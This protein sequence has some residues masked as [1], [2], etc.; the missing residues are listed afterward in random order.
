[1][2][3]G[4]AVHCGS[5]GPGVAGVR[6]VFWAAVSV[7]LA[8]MPAGAPAA[9]AFHGGPGAGPPCTGGR[10]SYS[11]FAWNSNCELAPWS[12]PAKGKSLS[13]LN[14]TCA[15]NL[16]NVVP[17]VHT[18]SLNPAGAACTVDSHRG[19]AARLS[20]PYKTAAPG[21]QTDLG[22]GWPNGTASQPVGRR[23]VEIFYSLTG[24][25]VPKHTKQHQPCIG[26]N[27]YDRSGHI[28][29]VGIS[30]WGQIHDPY[31]GM[32]KFT[33]YATS[34]NLMIDGKVFE[35]GF[36]GPKWA[37]HPQFHVAAQALTSFP[38]ISLNGVDG[39][40]V[41][42][43]SCAEGNA[44][45]NVC[46]CCTVV[47]ADPA[48]RCANIELKTDDHLK[49]AMPALHACSECVAPF[50]CGA[51]GD[52][53]GWSCIG[54]GSSKATAQCS[55]QDEGR[56]SCLSIRSAS[57]SFSI[58][59]WT[60]PVNIS[61]TLAAAG[62]IHSTSETLL[63]RISI[64]Y[65]VSPR[66]LESCTTGPSPRV[67][68]LL[69]SELNASRSWDH[70]P[71]YDL[72]TGK[73]ILCYGQSTRRAQVQT[74]RFGDV[75]LTGTSAPSNLYFTFWMQD[76]L[77]GT[78]VSLVNLSA[79]V[80]TLVRPHGSRTP[81]F[82]GPVSSEGRQW[83][84]TAE[85]PTH[86]ILGD[87]DES[88]GGSTSPQTQ[89]QQPLK[90][91]GAQGE[92]VARQLRVALMAARG[93][94][95]FWP[96]SRWQITKLVDSTGR[97]LD[98]RVQWARVLAV[99]LT[100][101]TPPY[102]STGL[103]PDPILPAAPHTNTV[104]AEKGDICGA[105]TLWLAFWIPTTAVAGVYHA[106]I[107]LVT[108]PVKATTT[109]TLGCFALELTVQPWAL[110][111]DILQIRSNFNLASA[112][113]ISH[114]AGNFSE[115]IAPYYDNIRCHRAFAGPETNI[116]FGV[117]PNG[118]I[119][120]TNSTVFV[121]E[122]RYLLARQTCGSVGQAQINV[123]LISINAGYLESGGNVSRKLQLPF[124]LWSDP[125]RTILTQPFQTFL[126]AAVNEYA[127]VLAREGSP[128]NALLVWKPTD[129][130]NWL[131]PGIYNAIVSVL[132]FVKQGTGPFGA[133]LSVR[134]SGDV[135]PRLG[136]A[137]KGL[138]DQWDQASGT[139][140]AFRD[141][142]QT[143]MDAGGSVS[144]YDNSVALPDQPLMRTRAHVWA[145]WNSSYA[146]ALCWYS[147]DNWQTTNPWHGG[148][149]NA[150]TYGG[151]L[152]YPPEPTGPLG[153]AARLGG[154]PVVASLRWE[155]MLDG[156]QDVGYFQVCHRAVLATEKKQ[157]SQPERVAEWTADL[158]FARRA[159]ARSAELVWDDLDAND[160]A[161]LGALA[162]PEF[163]S[164]WRQLYTVDATVV[165]SVRADLAAAIAQLGRWLRV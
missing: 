110:P 42:H 105:A 152:F 161:A 120:S 108:N 98:V 104:T 15:D 19:Q 24:G 84:I 139:I 17:L 75:K 10:A 69:T 164:S 149:S 30:V 143:E 27:A 163:M 137:G 118:S 36:S 165:E 11:A 125:A 8:P 49:L 94:T 156:I 51:G 37:H 79:H 66:T 31:A 130:P 127:A 112:N 46:E 54:D 86:R 140:S 122:L 138:V 133:R 18:H 102:G 154:D 113:D 157:P 34:T 85:H 41:R 9:A 116:V 33:F 135:E 141:E 134:I 71:K 146:G 136:A 58:A 47:E 73:G 144:V 38:A 91:A 7:L 101:A 52:S 45:D 159:L 109:T 123:P 59:G 153:S 80:T 25:Y 96:Q 29:P 74:M 77:G 90:L 61:A 126:A 92:R 83:S 124:A 158:A 148:A 100:S 32:A 40:V 117:S 13:A 56:K 4:T 16:S 114:R 88:H 145:L 142:L 55:C 68:G 63:L 132:T 23:A 78:T 89:M 155:A 95:G 81:L 67:M 6:G 87:S 128:H 111:T 43:N 121:Q 44:T 2:V 26:V 147:V 21:G 131:A 119:H 28:C 35:G 20:G 76:H 97:A 53:Q 60:A 65:R 82:V 115:I 62:A 99:N 1:M 48:A 103:T 3:H 70:L 39:A 129:E 5:R 162:R 107:S 151:A 160:V 72:A 50:E 93:N 12:E 106:N 14:F 22:G 57:T 64:V 150:N